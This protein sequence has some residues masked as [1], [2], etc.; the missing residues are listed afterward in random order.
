[1]MDRFRKQAPRF[2][3]VAPAARQRAALEEKNRTE[4]RAVVDRASYDI[5]K[6]PVRHRVV[7]DR[8]LHRLQ[9]GS[10]VAPNV[11]AKETMTREELAAMEKATHPRTIAS[12]IE[13]LP[14]R[15]EF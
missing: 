10:A 4:T 2:W 15:R 3:I 1:M 8:R 13:K 12:F 5:E 9:A 14:E 7:I 11:L 6:Q